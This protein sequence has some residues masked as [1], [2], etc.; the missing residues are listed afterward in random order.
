MIC[1]TVSLKAGYKM[2]DPQ[3]KS[4]KVRLGLLVVPELKLLVVQGLVQ[5]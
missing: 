4:F 1:G 2:R 5:V 3:T